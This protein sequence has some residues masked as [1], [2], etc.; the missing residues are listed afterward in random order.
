VGILKL[1]G[2]EVIVTYI[3]KIERVTKYF[4][5]SAIESKVT[6]YLIIG[7]GTLTEEQHIFV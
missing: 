1:V 7:C 3:N 5:P 2:V 6:M 4:W